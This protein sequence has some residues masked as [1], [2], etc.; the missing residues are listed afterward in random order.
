MQMDSVRHTMG[1]SWPVTMTVSVPMTT[2]G[3]CMHG[4][5]F[6]VEAGKPPKGWGDQFRLHSLPSAL[7]GSKTETLTVYIG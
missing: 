2:F 3:T 5:P 6:Q 4:R 1:S 7:G